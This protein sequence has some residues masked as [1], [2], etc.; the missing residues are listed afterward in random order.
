MKPHAR[1][2]IAINNELLVFIQVFAYLLFFAGVI[3]ADLEPASRYI[4]KAAS[5]TVKAILG[6]GTIWNNK[7]TC[8]C[9]FMRD[10]TCGEEP[11]TPQG[12]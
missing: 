11:S 9:G 8:T 10:Y 4:S 2:R 12:G 3:N 6:P 5:I 1:I 7:G